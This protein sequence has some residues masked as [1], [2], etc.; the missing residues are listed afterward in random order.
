REN[1]RV[2][3]RENRRPIQVVQVPNKIASGIVLPSHPLLPVE[4]GG[5]CG[6]AIFRVV[7]GY[8]DRRRRRVYNL[9]A[10]AALISI[11]AAAPSTVRPSSRCC[12]S[13]RSRGL[14]VASSSAKSS[15]GRASGGGSGSAGPRGGGL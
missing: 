11:A 9:R 14:A 12:A 3:R 4:K 5:F 8:P 15:T 10:V 2:A 13:T 1:L 6:T 7:T